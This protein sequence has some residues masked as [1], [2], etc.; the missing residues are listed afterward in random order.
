MSE[1]EQWLGRRTTTTVQLEVSQAN[2]MAV[3]LDLDPTFLAGDRLPPLWHWLY[4]H[5]LARAA[6][7]GQ[8]GHP[9]LGLFLPPVLLPRRM[10]AGGS[11]VFH[12]PL[13]LG[14]TVTRTSV[15]RSITPKTGRSGTLYFV[16]IEHTVAT[17]AVLN[18]VEEQN[19]V[20]RELA[21]ARQAGQA[22]LAPTSAD[23]SQ[24]YTVNST[25]LFRYSALTFNGH[26]IHY[27]VDYCREVEGYPNLVIHGPLIATLLLDLYSQQGQ[28]LHW[29][30]YRAQSPLFLPHPFTV[31]GAQTTASAQLWATNHVGQVAMTAEAG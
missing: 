9:K 11:F 2:R 29:L 14:E 26:R 7:L 4:F 3:T 10:W 19:I 5:D 23:Y 18:L 20:Y 6:D 28:P 12:A 25:T 21:T 1:F 22:Q 30:R 16:T 27:D 8:D 31:N 15:I 13:H 17:G 24:A